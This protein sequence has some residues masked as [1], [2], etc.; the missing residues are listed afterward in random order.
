MECAFEKMGDESCKANSPCRT[1]CKLFLYT[2]G[3]IHCRDFEIAKAEREDR[4]A[5]IRESQQ[6]LFNEG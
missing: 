2:L 6:D 5:D 1:S 3:R 4:D